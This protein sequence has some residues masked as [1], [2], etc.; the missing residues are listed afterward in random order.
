MRRACYEEIRAIDST[1]PDSLIQDL[2][3]TKS[4]NDM[5]DVLALSPYWNWFDTRLLEALVSASRSPEAEE[6]LEQFKQIHYSHR[7][8]EI[9][10][11]VSVVP[12]KNSVIITEKFKKE[13]HELTFLD[14]I[15]H[16][17]VLEYDIF[18]TREKMVLHSIKTGCVELTWQVPQELVFQAY[19]SMKMKH[20]EVSSLAIESLVCEEADEYIGLPFL[21][22]GQEVGK[23]GL[24]EPLPE[25]VRQEPYSLLKEFQ[26]IPLSSSDAD[27]VVNFID[28][29][30]RVKFGEIHITSRN[31]YLGKISH[32]HA[33]SEWQ[34]GIRATNG[35]LVGIVYAHPVC[36]SIGGVSITCASPIICIHKKYHNK[37]LWYML[38]KEF[39]RRAN[40]HK[41]NQFVQHVRTGLL[42]PI[43]TLTMW[44]YQ[45]THSTRLPN[46]PSTPGWRKITSEDVCSALA[47]VNKYASQFEIRQV[48]TSE[49]EFSHHFLCPTVP[50][51][52]FTY[53]VQNETKNITDLVS[54]SIVETNIK[55]NCAV[56]QAVV[57][58]QSRIQ[59]LIRDAFV[60]AIEDGAHCVIIYQFA[61]E[62]DV[63]S[64]LTAYLQ[65]LPYLQLFDCYL[66]NYKYHSVSEK[67]CCFFF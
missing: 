62:N 42:K 36:M 54:Y 23:V 19:S 32:P 2:K 8:N 29:N 17:R 27:K 7:V 25:H 59:D 9:L 57:S 45:L 58:T 46:S 39:Q 31:P 26:W 64:S 56:I 41:I 34:F 13:P 63:L 10:P 15:E 50:N 18:G 33:R 16:K 1:L 40:L 22:H 12:L 4:L 11:Y 3:P 20:D 48:F 21:W 5:L 44:K 65:Q 6:L 28:C 61:I 37:R 35:N 60:C 30:S 67:S 55:E 66:C 52:M 53:V 49:E 14:I 43:T 38:F 51:Y 24:I 47:L